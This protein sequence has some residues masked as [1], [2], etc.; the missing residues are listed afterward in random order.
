MSNIPTA[1]QIKS[2]LKALC[3]E[4][5]DLFADSVEELTDIL[6]AKTPVK[7]GNLRDSWGKPAR[8]NDCTFK[9]SN[10]ADYGYQVLIEG[11]S[12]QLPLGIL[13]TIR[14]WQAEQK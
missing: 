4:Q 5:C 7:T 10:N 9:L 11:K 14:Q 3:K 8:I 1:Q 2:S 6:K 12:G 13:P